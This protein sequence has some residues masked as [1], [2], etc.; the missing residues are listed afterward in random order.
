VRLGRRSSSVMEAGL[1]FVKRLGSESAGKQ[2]VVMRSTARE[3]RGFGRLR[4]VARPG[5]VPAAQHVRSDRRDREKKHCHRASPLRL[6]S[7][8]SPS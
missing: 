3:R 4:R 2:A 8:Q 5:R 1:L 7:K 6:P